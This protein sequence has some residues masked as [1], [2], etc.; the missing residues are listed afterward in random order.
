MPKYTVHLTV[1]FCA[2]IEAESL[3]AAEM[4]GSSMDYDTM[5]AYDESNYYIEELDSDEG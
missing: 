5:T 2:E 1:H 3:E 4:I